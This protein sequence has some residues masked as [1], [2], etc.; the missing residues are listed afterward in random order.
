MTTKYW[1]NSCGFHKVKAVRK[2]SWD[3]L[4]HIVYCLGKRETWD[5]VDKETALKYTP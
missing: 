5:R 1:Q 2:T 3:Q 4:W